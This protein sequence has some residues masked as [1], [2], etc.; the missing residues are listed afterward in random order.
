ME[1]KKQSGRIE[2]LLR[3]DRRF[4]PDEDFVGSA[5]WNDSEIYEKANQDLEG[6]WAEMAGKLDWFEPWDKVLEWNPPDLKWFVG[7]KINVC[8]NCLD[9]HLT[10]WRKNKAAIIWE[11]EGVRQRRVLTYQDL[12]REVNR[13]AAALRDLG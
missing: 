7:G 1:Q 5:N 6:F 2:A 8:Y 10:N 3:E 9:R 11:G 13:C 4:Q 12:Y